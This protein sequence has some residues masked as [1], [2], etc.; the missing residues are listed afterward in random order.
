M[1]RETYT[2][3]YWEVQPGGVKIDYL[4]NGIKPSLLTFL[5]KRIPEKVACNDGFSILPEDIAKR[6]REMWDRLGFMD[7]SPGQKGEIANWIGKGLQGKPLSIVSPVCPD[8]ATEIIDPGASDGPHK[9]HRFTF[10]G[11]GTGLG[12]TATHLFEILP[13]LHRFLVDDLGLTVNFWVCP[14]DFE[15]YSAENCDRLGV[16]E[17]AFL[18][19]IDGQVDTIMQD[20]PIA[21]NSAPLAAFCGGKAR[22]VEVNE[23]NLHRMTEGDR[24]H[25]RDEDWVVKT[26]QG[27]SGLY[28]RWYPSNDGS[29]EFYVDLALQQGAEYASMGQL[30][31]ENPDLQNPLVLGADDYKMGRFYETI[32]PIPIIYLLRRYE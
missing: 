21:V 4:Y 3:F 11:I 15:G 8:Y 30:I 1:I 10:D 14:G 32:S 17:D 13:E 31:L 2:D 22:W 23:S 9:R 28:D 27:R 5:L 29:A 6:L 7:V 25:L 16:T 26:A 24:S 12:V 18:R 19:A 20:A